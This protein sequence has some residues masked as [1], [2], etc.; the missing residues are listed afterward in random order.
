MRTPL[1]IW[2]VANPMFV[3]VTL[4]RQ[5]RRLQTSDRL[6]FFN[7]SLDLLTVNVVQ[8]TF[9]PRAEQPLQRP[10][11]SR[12]PKAATSQLLGLMGGAGIID[13]TPACQKAD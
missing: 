1:P 11:T 12:L 9:A 10:T 6:G 7:L 13:S 2:D 5:D 4:A 3:N 8:L